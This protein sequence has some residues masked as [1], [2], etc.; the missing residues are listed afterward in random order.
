MAEHSIKNVILFTYYVEVNGFSSQWNMIQILA[1][2][3]LT[4]NTKSSWVN[5]SSQKDLSSQMFGKT[6]FQI[7]LSRMST[8]DLMRNKSAYAWSS[9][10]DLTLQFCLVASK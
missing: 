7:L 6:R 10:K 8:F 9:L 2:V 1:T 4:V 3:Y 5:L